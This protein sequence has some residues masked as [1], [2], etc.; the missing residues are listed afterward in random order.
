MLEIL[1]IDSIL[2]TAFEITRSPELLFE[3]R[4]GGLAGIS[5][6]PEVGC[7]SSQLDFTSLFT[8]IGL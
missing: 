5:S 7:R 1:D 6:L 8:F 3:E 4:I 2:V